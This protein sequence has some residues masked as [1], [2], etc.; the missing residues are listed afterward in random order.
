MTNPSTMS[1][2]LSKNDGCVAVSEWTTGS[3]RRTRAAPTPTACE[4]M[5]ISQATHLPGL[6]GV[7]AR[8]LHKARPRVRRVVVVTD[9]RTA[10][11]LARGMG[12]TKAAAQA[13]RDRRAAYFAAMRGEE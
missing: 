9:R 1:H 13:A 8:R 3:G 12:Q 10:N 6:S 5:S 11:R 7:A 2:F 4:E